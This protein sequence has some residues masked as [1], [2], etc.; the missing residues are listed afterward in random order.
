MPQPNLSHLGLFAA[1]ARHASFQRAAAE[2]GM[3]TSA[4]SHAIR[5]LE[6]RLG[7]GLF[8]RTTRSVALTE[9]G[10]RLL[11]RLQP[12]LRDL[13]DALDEM[14]NFRTTPSGTLRINTSHVAAQML[15][16]PMLARFLAAYPEIHLEVA[17]DDGLVDIVAGG[18]DAGIRFQ[19]DVPED[20][21]GVRFGGV[22]R[23]AVVGAP[24]YFAR[25]PPPQHPSDLARHA[26]IRH[27][28]P[29][30]R[31]FKW[32]FERDGTWLEIDPTGP[33]TLT[34]QDTEARAML[35]GVGLAFTFERMAAA[36]LRDGRLVRV[37]DDW[38]PEYPGFM[39][40][41]PRQRRMSSALRAF[42]D[43]MRASPPGDSC[44]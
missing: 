25:H 7:V 6:E 34:D 26:C 8:N 37:L 5:G 11:E 12:A 18:F 14:N 3:S 10:Q 36:A 41:Y 42:I 40:Y 4:V 43:F 2:A 31:I 44:S 39:L 21:V 13:G 28:F 27:R 20:M 30:G 16:A 9:A 24:A 38:C 19:E 32:E 1:V 17:A 15:I 29:S 35:D 33:V 22:Q 23:F